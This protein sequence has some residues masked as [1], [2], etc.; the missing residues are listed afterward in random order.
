MKWI[1]VIFIVLA[2]LSTSNTQRFGQNVT[3]LQE[4]V[5]NT[6]VAPKGDPRGKTLL[7]T[8]IVF[9]GLYF[10]FRESPKK[11]EKKSS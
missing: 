2:L 9:A 4:G 11:E 8:I 1:I 10:I 5:T 7:R 3:S 6:L